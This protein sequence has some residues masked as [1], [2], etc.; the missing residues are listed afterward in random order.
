MVALEKKLAELDK[1]TLNII[2]KLDDKRNDQIMLHYLPVFCIFQNGYHKGVTLAYIE[3]FNYICPSGIYN[4][5]SEDHNEQ[6]RSG[7]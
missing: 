6:Y 2:N 3:E 4:I 7:T 1:H 5:S